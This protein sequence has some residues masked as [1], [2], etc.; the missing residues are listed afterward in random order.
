MM[1]CGLT[2]TAYLRAFGGVLKRC[3]ILVLPSWLLA[4]DNHHGTAS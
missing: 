2:T 3:A 4:L 1:P